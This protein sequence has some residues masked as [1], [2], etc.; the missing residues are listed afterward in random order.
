M[1]CGVISNRYV[2]DEGGRR[3]TTHNAIK[4]ANELSSFSG[5][6]KQELKFTSKMIFLR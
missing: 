4:C 2:L 1:T 3:G 5:I 6:D